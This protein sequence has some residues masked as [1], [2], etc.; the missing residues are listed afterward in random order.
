VA[1]RIHIASPLIILASIG[2]V[3]CATPFQDV[4]NQL[5]TPNARGVI[6]AIS[7]AGGSEAT[8]A[9]LQQE[10]LGAGLSL[11]LESVDWSH[12][13]GRFLSDQMDW[14]H[15]RREGTRLAKRVIAYR[16]EYPEG[17]VYLVGHSAGCGVALAAGDVLPPGSLRRIVLLAPSV[18]ADYD[19]RAALRSARDGIDVF[20]SSRDVFYLGLGAAIIGTP[21]RRWSSPAAGRIGFRQKAEC[22]EDAALYQKLRQHDWQASVEWTGNHGGHYDGFKPAYLRSYVLPLFQ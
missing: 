12:G 13:Y 20:F 19:L 3:G 18:S 1:S 4:S 15:A 11:N 6:F 14:E 7:G 22:S 9:A 16:Q 10:V 2:T 5:R 21:D 17:D 8:S